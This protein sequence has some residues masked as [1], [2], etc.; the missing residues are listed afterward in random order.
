M[1][2]PDTRGWRAGPGKAGRSRRVASRAGDARPGRGYGR[3]IDALELLAADPEAL[4]GSEIGRRLGLPKS[5]TFLMLQHLLDRGVAVLDPE[6][7]R[8][9]A[10]PV[11]LA[12]AHRLLGGRDLVRL[13]RPHLEALARE[14]TEDVYLG[15]SAGT[16]FVYVDKVVGTRSVGLDLRLGQPRHLHST[17][18]G[19]LFLAF[20]PRD[21]LKQAKAAHGLPAMTPAT[22]TDERRLAA[23]LERIR[24]RGWSESDGENVEGVYGLAAPVRDHADRVVAAV[25]ISTLQMRAASRR[26]HL[27]DHTCAAAGRISAALG[28]RSETE[29]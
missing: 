21:L 2:R 23:E 18:V 12:L 17:A 26:D 9:S 5:T 29:E 4:S 28:G 25:H 19:K 8:Y 20:G 1:P 13:A 6:T 24:A 14:T 27:I 22:I 11:L 16:K 3:V 7:R 15:V 10:G